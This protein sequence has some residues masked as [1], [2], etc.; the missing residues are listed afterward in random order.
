MYNVVL[1]LGG[2]ME[3]YSLLGLNAMQNHKKRIQKRLY[4]PAGWD[5]MYLHDI[6]V[7]PPKQPVFLWLAT[8]T[9]YCS[10]P[11]PTMLMT[12]LCRTPTVLQPGPHVTLQHDCSQF[13]SP[14]PTFSNDSLVPSYNAHFPKAPLHLAV[15]PAQHSACRELEF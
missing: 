14:I 15:N 11:G 5:Y 2:R 3:K 12:L 7:L 13:N 4:P 6:H 1:S 9:K 10:D 8:L